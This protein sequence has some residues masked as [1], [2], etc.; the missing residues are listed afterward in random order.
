M[1]LPSL[2]NKSFETDKATRVICNPYEEY[3]YPQLRDF[4]SRG[5][6]KSYVAVPLRVMSGHVGPREES[7]LPLKADMLYGGEES[8][9]SAISGPSMN[10]NSASHGQFA[11]DAV[12][13]HT[14]SCL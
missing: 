10:N 13:A 3:L 8:P 14:V 4:K 6:R 1:A 12:K 2:N 11:F 9:L 7:A 5:A